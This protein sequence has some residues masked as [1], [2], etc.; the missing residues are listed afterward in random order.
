MGSK[1]STALLSTALI[2]NAC[3]GERH[4][5]DG[6][7]AQIDRASQT[8]PSNSRIAVGE[9][10]MLAPVAGVSD[11]TESQTNGLTRFSCSYS[12]YRYE[13]GNPV[14]EASE[15]FELNAQSP[16]TIAVEFCGQPGNCFGIMASRGVAGAILPTS[17]GNFAFFVAPPPA[18]FKSSLP[19]SSVEVTLEPAP[20]VTEQLEGE[21]GEKK[22][23]L[24]ES[25]S[26]LLGA[27]D[28]GS[29]V[30]AQSGFDKAG[31]KQLASV[32]HAALD[33]A[34]K[35]MTSFSSNCFTR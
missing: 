10:S 25:W 11:A 4:P 29:F 35:P 3:S 23:V 1:I 8:N 27:K 20:N 7:E 33:D 19:S 17:D 13:Q 15:D 24:V 16:Q 21:I 31:S 34:G 18:K 5:G 2:L 6:D 28:S 30:S 12:K 26:Y 22:T 32:T 9:E 14:E